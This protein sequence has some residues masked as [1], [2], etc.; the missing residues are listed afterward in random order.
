M[1][2]TTRVRPRVVVAGAGFGG[3]R[4]ARRL[5]GA[6]FDVVVVDRRNYHTF[7]PL[8]YQVAAAE[9]EPGQVA[10]P[11]RGVFRGL[12]DIRF[13]LAEIRGIDRENRLL[14]T[15]GPDIPY[16][17]LV[18][19][20]GSETNHFGVP[21]AKAHCFGMKSLED[22][23]ALRNHIM[24][25]FEQASLETDPE[26][27]RR[28]LTFVVVGGGPTGV[29]FAG[30]LA[31]LIRGPLAKD[32]PLLN[33]SQARVVLLEAVSALLTPFPERLRE[34]ALL[35][36]GRMGV[37][38]C[39]GAQVG[40]VTPDA[41]LMKDGSE[42]PTRTVV[43]TAGVRGTELA[44]KLGFETGPGGRVP[45]RDTLQSQVDPNIFLIGDMALFTG[46]KGPLP[47]VGPVAMQQGLLAADN[48]KRLLAGKKLKPF[49]YHHKGIMATI[50]RAAAVVSMGRLNFTGPLAWA[51]WLFVHLLMLIGF[52]NRLAVVINWAW[53]YLFFERAARLLMPVVSAKC[54]GEAEAG[55]DGKNQT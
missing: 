29:E 17:C 1:E 41:V 12:R 19:A 25:M 45:V 43:W 3:L 50:G 37:E 9:L 48:V 36:L 4:T 24:N 28:L 27:Q 38:V 51:T 53:D 55:G 18:L 20:L 52:R 26:I 23:V 44:S 31:E 46:P 47:M 6:G 35:K 15:S 49:R 22:G 14:K 10:Y 40:R 42:L 39:L 11:V 32:Y 2:S 21:G 5:A 7:L 16:D 54:P 30:A 34:Y 13:A 33:L 8:L